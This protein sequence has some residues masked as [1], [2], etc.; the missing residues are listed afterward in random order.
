MEP[1]GSLSLSQE[2]T[3]GSVQILLNQDYILISYLRSGQI[4][5]SN[6]AYVSPLVFILQF[7]AYFPYFE[8]NKSRLM[9]SS[10]CVCVCVCILL[11]LLGNCSI[12]VP[13]SLLGNGW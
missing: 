3:T 1:E 7:L 5:P 2:P 10:C 8:K 12:K 11:S 4:Y 9:R 6:Y 13:L